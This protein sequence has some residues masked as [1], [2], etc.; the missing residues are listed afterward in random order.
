[1]MIDESNKQLGELASKATAAVSMHLP[2]T[3]DNAQRY[4]GCYIVP[5]GTLTYLERSIA[6]KQVLV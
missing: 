5:A 1:M 3:T 4:S 6:E 2:I